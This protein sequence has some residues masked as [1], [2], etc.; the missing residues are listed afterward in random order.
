M[1]DSYEIFFAQHA[2]KESF[3]EF[4]LNETIFISEE[5]A[6]EEWDALK[7]RIYSNDIV[8]MRGFGRDAHGTHLFTAFYKEVFGNDHIIKD[9]TNNAS[10]KKLIGQLTGL[11]VNRDLRN[12]QVS[13]I[14][15]RTKNIFTFTAP[16]NIVYIPKI[17]DPFT[18]HEAKGPY[19]DEYQVVFQNIAYEKF[20]PLIDDFNQIMTNPELQ[21]QIKNYIERLYIT[22]PN[23]RL[24]SEFEKALIRELSPIEL[25]KPLETN[26]PVVTKGLIMT[27]DQEQDNSISIRNRA[28][29]WLECHHPQIMNRTFKVSKHYPEQDQWWFT[30]SA[31]LFNSTEPGNFYLLLEKSDHE[32]DFILLDIPYEFIRKCKD[33]LNIRIRKEKAVF[34]LHISSIKASWLQTKNTIPISLIP[35]Q[36]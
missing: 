19:V 10:P 32:G 36:I 7:N 30:I 8:H 28:K 4:G 34:D 5:K 11:R 2:S 22:E 21:Q 15:G 18:G 12:Y 23:Q 29:T 13:H 26:I 35:F 25:P 1:K 9:S 14:F 6:A 20:K 3:F 27:T 17:I 33:R 31:D 24:V 16:W